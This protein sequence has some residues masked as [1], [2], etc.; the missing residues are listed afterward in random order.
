MVIGGMQ[1]PTNL[2]EKYRSDF[3]AV[4]PSVA[5]ETQSQIIPFILSGVAGNPSLNLPDGIHPNETGQIIV[6]DTVLDFLL[7]NNVLLK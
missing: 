2:G 7:Q 3:A 6:A 5:R 1:I 4:Y